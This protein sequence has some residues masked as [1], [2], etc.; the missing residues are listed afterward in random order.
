MTVRKVELRPLGSSSLQI[1]PLGLGCWQFSKGRGVVG[2]YWPVLSDE[3]ITAIVKTSIEGGINWL[4][5]A[6][7]YG[8]G[9]SERALDRA[10]KTLEAE[11]VNTEQVYIATKWWP[12]LRS[13]SSLVDTI[14]ERIAALGGRTIDLYQIHQPFSLSAI[15]QEMKAMAQLI[16]AGKIRYAGVSNYSEEQMRKAH[17]ALK[18]YGIELVSN[19]VKYSIYDRRI[20]QNGVLDA[21]KELGMTIIAFSPLE[22]GLLTGKFHADR[23]LIQGVRRFQPGFSRRGLEKSKPLIDALQR[24]AQKYERTASQIALNWLIHF[25]GDTVVAIPGA[26]KV[27]HAVENVGAMHFKLLDNE[28]REL[29]DTSKKVVKFSIQS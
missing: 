25:H 29:D 23:S 5:T 2:R 10:L 12:A 15:H 11:G 18:D 27:K 17:A 28:L 21:A 1:S 7:V 22:Q 20:E 4:D 14:D 16:R 8:K 24:L 6:E 9:E 13:A 3:D 26:S 19:Q